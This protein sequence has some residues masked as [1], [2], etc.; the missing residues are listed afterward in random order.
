LGTDAHATTAGTTAEEAGDQPPLR[1]RG[2]E[3]D[4]YAAYHVK[5]VRKIARDVH[6][7]RDNVEDACAFA[8]I[9]FLRHQP[10]RDRSWEGWL[11]KV[12]KHEAF[13][14]TALERREAELIDHHYAERLEFLSAVQELKKLAPL[15][16]EAVMIRSQVSTQ[17]EVAEIMGLS[18]QR[19]AYLLT[20]AHLRV[21]ELNEERHNSERPVASPRAARLRE[22]EDDPPAWLKN[23]IGTRPGRSKSSSGVVLA[24]RRA[25][26]VLDDYRHESGYRSATDAIGAIPIDPVARRAYQRAERAIKEVAD[27]RWR[28][29]HGLGR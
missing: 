13:R 20:Q 3:L 18:R 25:A 5:L 12:A 17:R 22:L 16:Q 7:S 19:V 11:Y 26:L 24:W 2:D 29:G 21:A 27:E 6:T 28:R 10:D 1:L 23:A 9:Q 8:W 14:L 4:L 15:H